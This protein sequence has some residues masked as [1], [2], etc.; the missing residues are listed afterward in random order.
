MLEVYVFMGMDGDGMS[1]VY[2]PLTVCY[3]SVFQW[4]ARAPHADRANPS[5]IINPA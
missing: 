4:V 1:D 2:W 3:C 5:A